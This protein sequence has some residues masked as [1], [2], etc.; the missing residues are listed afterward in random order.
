VRKKLEILARQTAPDRVAQFYNLYP[1]IFDQ[2]Q[3]KAALVA[4]VLT[5]AQLS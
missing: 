4:D 1:E 5:Q 2:Q 3:I